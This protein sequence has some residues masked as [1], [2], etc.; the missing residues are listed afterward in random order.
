MSFKK[1]AGMLIAL[2]CVPTQS[3]ASELALITHGT[4]GA[5]YRDDLGELRGHKGAGKRAF[6]VE[7]VRAMQAHLNHSSM[8]ETV[9]F[10]RGYR[11][12]THKTN[13][14]LFNLAR[15]AEREQ[16]V[17]WVGPLVSNITYFY[18]RVGAPTDIRS[19]TD[20]KQ[21]EKICVTRGNAAHRLLAA[22]G[23][24]NLQV[25]SSAVGCFRMLALGRVNLVESGVYTLGNTI[26][27]A[28][29]DP[30]TIRKTSV[31]LH[32]TQGYLALSN[33][34][35]L[36]QVQQWQNALDQVKES[37]R[38][39]QLVTEYLVASGTAQ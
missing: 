17:Q 1:I 13:T 39:S 23:F 33:D 11:D 14:A 20:A 2:A 29:I 16:A 10:L 3:Q 21:V 8:V 22:D 25:S 37:G 24:N 15:T 28:G 5:V 7:L 18:E 4:E 32:R 12:V 19:L 6:A 34:V 26:N 27:Q 30:Q 31:L 38:Y 9:P 36:E 35:P